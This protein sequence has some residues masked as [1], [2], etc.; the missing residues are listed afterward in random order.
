MSKKIRIVQLAITS[1]GNEEVAQY[2]DDK[3]RV[4]Y[5]GGHWETLAG[6]ADRTWIPKW[7]QLDLPDE[8]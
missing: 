6:E 3:G 7:Y 4:W 2:L 1:V 8:P 5:E